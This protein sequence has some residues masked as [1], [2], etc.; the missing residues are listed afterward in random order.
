MILFIFR[1]RGGDGLILIRFFDLVD[2]KLKLFCIRPRVPGTNILKQMVI[3]MP[4]RP[5][6]GKWLHFLIIFFI[7]QCR[8]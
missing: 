8:N 1:F 2:E 3:I 6:V 5:K 7:G 4:N